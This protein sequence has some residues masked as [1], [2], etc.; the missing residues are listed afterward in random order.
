MTAEP[1]RYQRFLAVTLTALAFILPVSIAGTNMALA[2]TL[3]GLLVMMARREPLAWTEAWTPVTWCLCAYCAVAVVTSLAGVAPAHSLRDFPK[4]LHK[5]CAVAILLLALRAAPARRLPAALALGF[6]FVAAFGIARSGLE[7]WASICGEAGAGTWVRARGFV[8]AVTYGDMLALGLLGGLS[9]IG[10]P[11]AG[12]RRG[13]A[14]V[15]LGLLAA[16]LLLNQTRAAF[17]SLLAG[18]AVMA[19]AAPP[20]RRWLKWGLLVAL[21]GVLALELLPT[22]RSIIGSLRAYG[23]GAGA[24]PQFQRLILWE[25]AWR[26]FLDHPWL[27]VGPANYAT[28]FASYFQGAIEGQRV[29]GSAHNLFLH[30]LAERGL[31]GFAALSALWCALLGRAWQRAKALP[32]LCNLWALGATGAFLV[33]NLTENAFQSEQVTT[34][35][36]FIWALAEARAPDSGTLASSPFG[37]ART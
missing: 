17:L 33:M 9:F 23:A 31:L 30:Q 32:D 21:L 25:V 8:H 24:N 37:G 35:F 11:E 5:L 36:L 34:L 1:M 6:V 18:F 13:P 7:S 22:N 10:Q 3:A 26:A 2:W 4:D 20:L 29:W 28:V 12:S 14:A 27:G 19:A 16:A 15:F